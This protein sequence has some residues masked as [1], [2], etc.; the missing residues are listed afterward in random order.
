MMRDIDFPIML[1]RL[2][3]SGLTAVDIA[4]ATGIGVTDIR[5]IISESRPAPDKW[6]EAF[7]LLDLWLINMPKTQRQLPWLGDHNL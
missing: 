3:R 7:K 6:Q 5:A 1:E 2:R 4:A